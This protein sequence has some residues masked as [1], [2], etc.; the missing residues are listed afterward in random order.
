MQS[1]LVLSRRLFYSLCLTQALKTCCLDLLAR[2]YFDFKR[3]YIDFDPEDDAIITLFTRDLSH[4]SRLC[5]LSLADRQI[6]QDLE[7]KIKQL[8]DSHKE[9]YDP[10]YVAKQ[11][12]AWGVL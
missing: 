2:L 10:H 9:A 6:K 7:L 3:F 5:S 12:N 11:L 4:I 8:Y 1:S